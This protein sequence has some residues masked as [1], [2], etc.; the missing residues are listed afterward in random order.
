MSSLDTKFGRRKTVNMNEDIAQE[1]NKL[2]NSSGKTL[3]SLIN[4][5]GVCALEANRRG[6]SLEDAVAAKKLVQSAR[7]SRMVLVNQDLWY[8]AG[9]QAMKASKNRWLKLIRDSAQWQANVFLTGSS[10]KEFVES[11]RALLADFF[12]DCSEIKLEAQGGDGLALRLA[13]VP[14][15]PLEHTEGVFKALEGMFNAHQYVVTDSM[16]KPGFLAITFKRISDG[17]SSST[18]MSAT[19]RFRS[20]PSPISPDETGRPFSASNS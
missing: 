17:S 16:V 14:E 9:S 11:V 15:M 8:F 1:L 12:W 13:F 4:E 10:D 5:I 6:F 20:S 2:A 18:R 3:Y 19:P 7:R